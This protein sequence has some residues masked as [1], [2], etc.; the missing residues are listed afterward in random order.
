MIYIYIL[1]AIVLFGALVAVHEFGHFITAKL[2]GVRVNEFAIG[3]GPAIFKKKIG[4]TVYALRVLPLGG[5]CAMEGE[6]STSD[7]PRAFG[8][9]NVWKRIL[10]VIAGSAMNLIAGFV[11]LSIVFAPIRSWYTTTVSGIDGVTEYSDKSLMPGDTVKSI[12]GYNVYIYSDIFMGISRGGEDGIYDVEVIRDGKKLLLSDVTLRGAEGKENSDEGNAIRFEIED[13]SFWS[14]IKYTALNGFNLVRLVKVG[15]VDLLGG[16]VSKDDL[17]GPVGIGKIMADTAKESLA[18][19]WYLL[20]FLS[21]NL[22]V[23]NL[24]PIPALDGGRLVFL[25][26]ELIFGKPV[27]PKYEGFIHAAGLVL[28]MLLMAFITYNDIVKIFVK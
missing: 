17:S 24:L 13:S 5:F 2:S 4:E 18:S 11:V 9:K 25:V 19:L 20:A 1:L 27:A 3:M 7:D 10:I 12:D 21:I 8:T 14:K 26:F 22:G 15:L 23:M 28:L 6:D 16:A